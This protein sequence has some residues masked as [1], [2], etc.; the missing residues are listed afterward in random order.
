MLRKLVKVWT[1]FPLN[2]NLGS[3]AGIVKAQIFSALLCILAKKTVLISSKRRCGNN[4][5][6]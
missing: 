2:F 1:Y 3:V 5:G 4:R 6:K